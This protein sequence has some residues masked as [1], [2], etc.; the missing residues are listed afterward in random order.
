LFDVLNFNS[1]FASKVCNACIIVALFS[2]LSSVKHP[3]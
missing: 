2:A 3:I 1:R